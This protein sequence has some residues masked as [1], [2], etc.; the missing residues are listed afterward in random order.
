MLKSN[1]D[2]L[3]TWIDF[4][5]R[6]NNQVFSSFDVHNKCAVLDVK[7]NLNLAQD[8]TCQGLSTHYLSRSQIVDKLP[9]SSF[10]QNWLETKIG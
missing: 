2:F 8:R 9:K 5:A 7:A 3:V 4:C 6:S 1:F 10:W